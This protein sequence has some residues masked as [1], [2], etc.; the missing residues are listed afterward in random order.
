MLF[1]VIDEQVCGSP[2]A[3]GVE[4]ELINREVEAGVPPVVARAKD[5]LLGL[6][7]GFGPGVA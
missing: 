5:R 2:I 6:R 1:D 7:H 3:F 4:I